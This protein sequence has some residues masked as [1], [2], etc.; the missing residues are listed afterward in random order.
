MAAIEERK[1]IEGAVT[2]RVK[3]RRKGYSTLSKTFKNKTDAKKFIRKIES[4]IDQGKQLASSEATKRTLAEAIDRYIQF[5]LPKKPR[6]HRQQSPQLQW[7]KQQIGHLTLVQVT[8]AVLAKCRELLSSE[9]THRSPLRSNSTVN[10]YMAVIS[11]LFTVAVKEWEWININ[12][13]NKLSKLSEPR[14]RVRFLSDDERERLLEACKK[15]SN[16][17]LYTIVV[18]ALST[19]ARKNEILSLTRNDVDLKQNIVIFRDTKNKSTRSVPLLCQA[20][21]L[22]V[23]VLKI[24]NLNT[25]LLFPSKIHSL[26]PFDIRKAWERAIRSSGIENFVFHDLRHTAASYLTM[27]G[28]SL[29]EVA[30][31]LG[32]KTLNMAQR[33]SH[34]SKSHLN[35]VIER[36][37]NRMSLK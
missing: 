8:P 20:R 9:P 15:S 21:Q 36:M 19:G 34:L 18:I 31:I 25:T 29:I 13:C 30:E 32:H 26:Q 33:Y 1:N 27:S 3:I 28:A 12:P 35:G 6:S 4:D 16:E 24:H 37:N 23:E 11:H 7:W 14:G 17:Y 5:A 10:R 22:V 2:Y